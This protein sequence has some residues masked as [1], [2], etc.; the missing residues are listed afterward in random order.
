[1]P[2]GRIARRG[3]FHLSYILP[4]TPNLCNHIPMTSHTPGTSEHEYA[5][6]VGRF[7]PV[8]LGHTCTL[9][10]MLETYGADKCLLVIGSS[11]A[12]FSLR[13]FFSY[14]ERRQFIKKLYPTLRVV[15]LAD[16]GN[17]AE[18]LSALDDLII[19]AGMDPAKTA[20]MGGCEEDVAFFIDD[21]RK[22]HIVNRFDGSS[23]KISATEV[24]DCLIYDRPLDNF[25]HPHL[26]ADI[27]TL[28]KEKW[29]KFKK[30]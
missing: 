15:G 3:L 27:K 18:W 1:M 22:C 16:F 23:V 14:N 28:F 17:D 6:Y 12:P 21:G 13:H 26:I 24:R 11:S 25:V 19:A 8:H 10:T 4:I 5:L 20:F 2:A 30:I 29:E 9:D 7:N